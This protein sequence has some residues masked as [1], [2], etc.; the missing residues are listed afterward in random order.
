MDPNVLDYRHIL[1]KKPIR[2]FPYDCNRADPLIGG[3]VTSPFVKLPSSERFDKDGLFSEE[4]FGEIGS[5]QR[6]IQQGII[7]LHTTVF[8]PMVFMDMTSS[9]KLYKEIMAG[10]IWCVF[11]TEL[12]DFIQCQADSPDADT[13]FSFFV[14]NFSRI[15]W[16][17]DIKSLTVLDKIKVIK[18]FPDRLLIDR[19]IVIPAELREYRIENGRGSSDEINGLYLSLLNYCRLDKERSDKESAIYDSIRYKI[20]LKTVEIYE[21]ISDILS[22]DGYLEKKYGSRSV[23]WGTRNVI[24]PMQMGVDNVNSDD[25]LDCDQTAVPLFQCAKCFQLIAVNKMMNLFFTPIISNE[26]NQIAAINKQTYNLEFIELTEKEKQRFIS[27]SGIGDLFNLFRNKEFR[28]NRLT[29]FDVNKKQY[30][31][32][33]VYDEGDAIYLTR[34]KSDFERFYKM[35]F[36]KPIDQDKL[37]PM[38]LM[39][40]F[41]ISTHLASYDKHVLITR[42]PIMGTDSMYPS[43]IKLLTTTPDRKVKFIS[44]LND[45]EIILPNYPVLSGEFR[46][47][48]KLH[49][50]RLKGL[51][52]DHDGDQL[53]TIGV[54]SPQA[55]EEIDQH[56]NSL[57]YYVTTNKNLTID[58]SGD[59]IVE[60]TLYCMS[61][62]R[63]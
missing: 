40:L 37:R 3:E 56:I 24:S 28:K 33:L 12:N 53:N 38:T 55:N 5:Q 47:S 19:M 14:K 39:E 11:D 52:A 16:N 4:I 31:L 1:K 22:N 29:I 26:T 10:N 23:A 25:I 44:V 43:K 35:K 48:L 21:Y 60:M 7:R 41:Y 9:R 6:S 2:I 18:Q 34:S 61:W 20:Q 42:Y 46:D 36:N 58:A 45:S 27:T 15:K 8:H 49:P 57:A 54:L 59:Y 51:T 63:D 13:G 30:Y 62:M 50:S 32:Y 17:T